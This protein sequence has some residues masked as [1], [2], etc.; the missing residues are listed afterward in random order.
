M[1]FQQYP[2]KG[3]IPSGNTAGRPG[4]PVI[5][6]TY[7]NGQLEIL[8]I[9]NGTAWVAVSAPP[10]TPQLVSVTDASTSDA[11]SAT[12]GKIS[13]AFVA[14]SGGGT[15][16][17]YNAFT[18]SGGFSSSSSSSTVT[19]SG[20]TPG[21]S[22]TFYGNAQ[23]NFGTTVNTPN[24]NAITPTTLPQVPTIGTA[25]A[26]TSSNAITVTWTLG[27][28]GGKNLTAVTITPY[29]N[30]TTAQTSVDAA[31][32]SSTSYTFTNLTGGSSYTFKVKAS[33]ANGYSAESSATNSATFPNLVEV[34]FLVV[35][36]AGGGGYGYYGGGG[37]AGGYR[38]SAGTSGANSSAESKLYLTASTN[39]TVTVGGGG[40][41]ST[42]DNTRATSGGNSVFSTIT[43]TGGG[44]GGSRGDTNGTPEGTTRGAAGG[45]GGG[46]AQNYTG[47]NLGGL[48][49]ANQGKDGGTAYGGGGGGASADGATNSS[50]PYGGAGG[51]GLASTITGSSVTRAGGG[52]GGQA[53]SGAGNNGGAGG[54]GAGGV[55]ANGTAGSANT[56]G[57]G[58]GGGINTSS[59]AAGGSGIVILRYPSTRTITV[60]AG[61]TAGVTN[62]TVGTNEKYTTL[63]AGSGNVSWS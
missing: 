16:A 50:F 27:N 9:W 13:I 61:L 38:T 31:T 32:T 41:G 35:A 18:T 24:S 20:L 62:Q 15:P 45:S 23:N 28:N 5:G 6:D 43:S 40:A 26:S 52:G 17:Q 48:G 7:Y 59:G 4:S 39:Y 10:S 34:D 49:T 11:Y 63:T 21:T 44:G 46:T 36:G 47:G 3:G 14:G 1:P 29:L 54:G 58:G 25:T 37:G 2:F 57:G 42:A 8:E 56:G 60:G 55:A 33:N 53:S 12:G 22:Y 30:G 51:A 19:I